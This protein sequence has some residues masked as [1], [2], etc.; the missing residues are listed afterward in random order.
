MG[1]I[2]R[3]C[4]VCK[5]WGAAYLLSSLEGSTRR[6]CALCWQTLQAVAPQPPAQPPD[7]AR[8][9]DALEETAAK[10]P[11]ALAWV[12]QKDVFLDPAGRNVRCERKIS[13]NPI[14]CAN[15]ARFFG[16]FAPSE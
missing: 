14:W 10:Q 1:K 3:R 8:A 4:D 15:M 11:I 5:A 6:L 16:R 12:T 7:S 2:L 13:V 9:A